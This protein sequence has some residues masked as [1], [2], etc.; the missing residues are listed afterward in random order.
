MTANALSGDRERCLEVGMNDYV[1]KPVR[2]HD[3]VSVL[4]AWTRN[5]QRVGEPQWRDRKQIV[6]M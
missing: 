6:S 2:M 5:R 1:A 4:L 3:V